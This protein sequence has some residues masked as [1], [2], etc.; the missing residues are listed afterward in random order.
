M[1]LFACDK[2]GTVNTKEPLLYVSVVRTAHP[3]LLAQLNVGDEVPISAIGIGF[4]NIHTGA[5]AANHL[6][7]DCA[8]KTVNALMEKLA[9][10]VKQSRR[11][12]LLLDGSKTRK[13]KE[14]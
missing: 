12:N 13:G 2:C 5:A 3:T 6:C 4:D 14:F 7:V 8:G 11:Q 1:Q 10:H 9:A